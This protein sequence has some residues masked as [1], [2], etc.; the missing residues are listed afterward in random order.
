MWQESLNLRGEGKFDVV[1]GEDRRSE[2][3]IGI[4]RA[5]SV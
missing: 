4:M 1:K 2:G 3:V 5:S